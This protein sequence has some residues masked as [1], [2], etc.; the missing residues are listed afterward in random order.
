MSNSKRQPGDTSSLMAIVASIVEAV[1]EGQRPVLST[2]HPNPWKAAHRQ[3]MARQQRWR[4]LG[5]N[6][7]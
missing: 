1:L 7:A 3:E 2:Q 6:R 4:N 5:W